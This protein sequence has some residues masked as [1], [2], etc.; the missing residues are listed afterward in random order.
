MAVEDFLDLQYPCDISGMSL[1]PAKAG[2]F[3]R[4]TLDGVS[5]FNERIRPKKESGQ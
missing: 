5:R 4:V 2:P 1:G 3:S